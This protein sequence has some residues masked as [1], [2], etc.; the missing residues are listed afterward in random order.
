MPLRFDDHWN[1]MWTPRSIRF[2]LALATAAVGLLVMS[3]P[4]SGGYALRV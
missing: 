2:G 4:P 3:S 1:G